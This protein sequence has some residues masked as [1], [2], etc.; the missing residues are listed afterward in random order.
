MIYQ[1]SRK[2]VNKPVR[3]TDWF[4]L[5]VLAYLVLVT[6]A[7]VLT[8]VLAPSQDAMLYGFIQVQYVLLLFVLCIHAAIKWGQADFPLLLTL[9]LVPLIRIISISLPLA[10]FPQMYWYLLTSIPIFAATVMVMRQLGMSWR[11]VGINGRYLLWQ[12]PITLAGF[13]IGFI[14]YIILKPEPLVKTFSWM[15]LVSAALILLIGTG[16]LEELVFRQLMQKV[17]VE[18]L[19]QVVG[20]VYVAAIFGVLHIGYSS[21]T[22][23]LFVFAVGLFF[24]W[25][26]NKTGSIVGVT[27]AHGVA[28]I[29]LF[30]IMPLL[31]FEAAMPVLLAN[32]LPPNLWQ[33]M[34]DN[35]I[36]LLLLGA[37]FGMMRLLMLEPE[38]LE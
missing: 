36:W 14:E 7:E 19:G 3:A 24:G 18:R 5:I 33:I 1:S 15:H 27:M 25:A 37:G 2:T 12:I 28:N 22:D 21:F 4:P 31:G 13:V 35:S 23:V 10:L 8:T 34:L 38:T 17:A 11:D 16:F 6:V 26:V 29:M 20:I 9:T 30:L 32:Q